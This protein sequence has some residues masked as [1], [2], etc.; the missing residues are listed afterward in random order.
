MLASL[1]A[2]KLY[3]PAPASKRVQRPRLV[4]RLDEGLAAGRQLTL[5]SAPAGFGKTTCA[6]DWINAA[7]LPAAWL[8]LDA[9]DDDPGHF[10]A[11][12][13]AALQKMDQS[14]NLGREI[15][16]VL[17]AGQLPPAEVISTSLINEISQLEGRFLLVLDDFQVIQDRFILQVMEMLV[18]NQPQA[19]HL[20]LITREDPSLPLARLRANN[21]M[22]EIRAGDLRFSKD[23]TD[24]F[25]SQVLG[26]SLSAADVAL[27]EDR[28]EGW[29]VGLQLAGFSIRDHA[30][31]SSFIATLSGSHRFILSYLIQEVLSCQPD[32]IQNF[33][34]DTSILDRLNGDLC[35]AVTGRSDSRFLLERLLNAN[36]FLIA[37][38]DEQHWYRYH[39]LFADLLRDRQKALHKDKTAP[40]H[41]RASRWYAQ[42]GM[43]N[44][45]IQNALAAADYPAAAALI[46]SHAMDTLMQGS[47]KTVEGWMQALPA[48]WAFQSPRANFAF[49]WMHLMRRT[50]AQA[51]PYL[52]RLEALFSGDQ[53]SKIDA[54][55]QG[56]WLALQAMLRNA[57]GK[58]SESLDLANQALK[59]VPETDSYVRGLIFLGLAN[60]YQQMGEPARSAE[61]YRKLIGQDRAVNFACEILGYAGL[62]LMALQH[63][64]L[65][66]AFETAWQGIERVERSGTLPP[67]STTLYGELGQVYFHWHQ[68]EQARRYFLRSTQVST[69]NG[70]RDAEIYQG[71]IFS[72]LYQMKGDLEAA[73]REIQKSVDLLQTVATASVQEEVFSQQIRIDLAQGHLAAAETRFQA[74]GFSRQGKFYIPDLGPDDTFSRHPGEPVQENFTEQMGLLY[75]SALRVLLYR[76]QARG[77]PA[78]LPSAIELAGRLL[79]ELLQRQYIP[80][81]L[82]TLLLRAQLH[83]ALGNSPACLADT[84]SALEL[85]EPEGF[86]TSFVE[87]GPSIARALA[88][89]PERKQPGAVQPSY[90]KS[91][92]EAFSTFQSPN[93]ISAAPAEAEIP[94]ALL[95]P[96]TDRELEVMRLIAD[97]LKYEEIAARLFISLNTVRTY[98]KEIYS[99]FNVNNRTQA[100][101]IARQHQLI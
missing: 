95:E 26:L 12:L 34:L 61:A 96:L 32:E 75:N 13:I 76:A 80:A 60:T 15:E 92:L 100:I 29:I 74:R 62:G 97:G 72:R 88:A 24:C 46:E 10:F 45:A 77:E 67:I 50:Y 59:I 35:D 36:L 78:S 71:V 93:S 6:S 79:S 28:T 39:T 63:G 48:E 4:Q 38:D 5:I 51:S 98:V 53:G 19:L 20:V 41:Q 84:A 37:L 64:Q 21:R 31:P 65:H 43:I 86:I 18:T 68:L 58:A 11:Y 82:E 3:R 52:E 33:L 9:S 27:L 16:S 87:E 56:E 22:T 14:A 83:A 23:E 47:V 1:L 91:I 49:A 99:K 69:L 90:V 2:T 54:S 85:A 7:G 25:L 42:A 8:S 44:E 89:L 81:A 55:L 17:R 70:Y 66:S 101:A 30:D 73:A 57:Q 40:L 94:E